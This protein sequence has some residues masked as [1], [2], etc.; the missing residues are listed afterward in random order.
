[1]LAEPKMP[2]D[3]LISTMLFN[4][5]YKACVQRLLVNICPISIYKTGVSTRMHLT[6]VEV[7]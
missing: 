7:L 1:M 6:I 3:T 2:V 5:D 4:K